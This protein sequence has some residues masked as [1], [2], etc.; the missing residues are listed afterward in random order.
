MV[1]VLALRELRPRRAGGLGRQGIAPLYAA[2]RL[3]ARGVP[4]PDRHFESHPISQRN[5]TSASTAGTGSRR[6]CFPSRGERL[7]LGERARV[8]LADV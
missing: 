7:F 6:G 3:A 5:F 1:G 4:P 8:N 2:L